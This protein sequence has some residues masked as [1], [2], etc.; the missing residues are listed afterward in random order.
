M[1]NKNL[2][3]PDSFVGLE[4]SYEKAKVVILPVP[5]EGTVTYKK[6]ASRGP[7]G[8]IEASKHLEMYDEELD[9]STYK[10]GM[11]TLKPLSL[12]QKEKPEDIIKKVKEICKVLIKDNKFAV[13]LGGEHS[14]S[15]GYYL[16]LKGKYS[17]LSVVQL[18]AHADLREEYDET[19]YSHACV[20]ARIRESCNKVVQIGIR[21]LSEE[22]AL[23]IK[24]KN[25]AIFYAHNIIGKSEWHDE[26][27]KKLSKNVFVTIDTD[28]FDWNVAE[29]VGTPEPG[30]IGWYQSLGI[31][32]SI[33][34]NKN[35]VGFDI[36]ELAPEKEN[37]ESN[38][39]F[40][41]A[42]LLYRLIGYKFFL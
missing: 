11:C 33:F 2:S 42:K 4:D 40:A 6:G 8:I 30:G 35:V 21:S 20:I 3:W 17:D 13:V 1:I 41:L 39:C 29:D 28:F 32:R 26:M 18:D 14:I 22:E 24:K 5:Y 27:L 7:A 36:V 12:Q 9:K 23:K 37:K 10:I 19:K 38:S 31:L 34:K 16:A 25:Y 15:L